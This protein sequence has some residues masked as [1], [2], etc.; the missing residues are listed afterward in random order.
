MTS[1][2]Y[3]RSEPSVDP[4]QV[5]RRRI[6][7]R[8]DPALSIV[9]NRLDGTPFGQS[10]KERAVTVSTSKALGAPIDRAGALEAHLWL[11]ERA[12]GEGL[13][14]TAAGYL[15]PADV[16]ELATRLPSMRDWS[17]AVG[18]ESDTTPVLDFREYLKGIGLV[19][20]Y[21]GSLRLTPAGRAASANAE[22]LWAYIADTLIL[23]G[24]DFETDAC[25]LV[26]VH[27]ATTEGRID[28]DLIARTMTALGWSLEGGVPV[29]SRELYPV[30]NDLWVALGSIGVFK[31][32]V[33]FDRIIGDAARR[34]V[35]ETLF[36]EVDGD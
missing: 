18:R 4:V 33:S 36:T 3:R 34:M 22:S 11:L 32:E 26:L 14:L 23:D 6:V 17:F 13:P 1:A 5:Q 19:R 9:L 25:V 29:S 28:L 12:A 8:L 10:F 21:K 24:S 20:K 15:K 30:W 27:M 2:F 16:K 31:G 7:W 35:N